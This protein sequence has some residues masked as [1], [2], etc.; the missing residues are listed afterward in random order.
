MN[1]CKIT[2]HRTRPMLPSM[3]MHEGS[4]TP[5]GILAEWIL[6]A[7]EPARAITKTRA[8]DFL[9]LHEKDFWF[10][11]IWVDLHQTM[12]LDRE[13][14]YTRPV[15]GLVR[16]VCK[17][18]TEQTGRTSPIKMR[19]CNLQMA[20]KLL[21]LWSIK[22]NLIRGQASGRCCRFPSTLSTTRRGS[23]GE[24]SWDI[25]F[26]ASA[27]RPVWPGRCIWA[28]SVY[29]SRLVPWTRGESN[30]GKLS[31]LRP[32]GHGRYRFATASAANP[33]ETLPQPEEVQ[34]ELRPVRASY[35]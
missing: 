29:R 4:L 35:Q 3:R 31:A 13:G 7:L 19:I 25:F 10:K 8:P 12:V 5:S 9:F 21:D 6:V 1:T 32:L 33:H 16:C 18:E 30:H 15:L 11:Q 14:S 23:S 17:D 34:R 26:V 27:F 22:S 2:S 20:Q 24:P 28:L